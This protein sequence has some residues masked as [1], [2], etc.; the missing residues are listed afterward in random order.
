MPPITI[1]IKPASGMCNM[2]C[3]YCFY[4][5]VA[6]NRELPNYGIMSLSTLE[7]LMKKVFSY[8]EGSASFIFQGGEPTLAGL[9]FFGAVLAYQKEYNV[10]GVKV[11]NAIQTNGYAVTEEWA[12]FF[13]ENNFLVGL[14]LDGFKE[15]HDA[16][17]VD[18]GGRG[19]YARV[20]KT[21]AL[22]DAC[23]VE[24]NILCVVDKM[25]ARHPVK[26]YRALKK[27]RYLQF[28]PCMDDFD[29]KKQAH[30]LTAEAYGNFLK[31]TFDLYYADFIAGT[32]VSVRT[33]DNYI[34]ML[35]GRR[36]ESCAMNGVCGQYFLAEADGGIYPCDFY[37]L[38]DWCLGNVNT[39]TFEQMAES[40]RA[41]R[42]L[43]S[44][45][46]V[47]KKCRNCHWFRL[48][49]GGCRRDREPF[50]NGRPGLNR[51]CES[52]QMFFEYALP[53]MRKMALTL[54]EGR[55]N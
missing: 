2:R 28:I 14:S 54:A 29:G 34:G 16:V 38:D 17:R 8:A 19:T 9:D 7:K 24:Y 15:A 40:E 23:G 18:S 1:M 51:Y 46:Y 4:A 50:E 42:F 22:F 45:E 47:D 52:Y 11:W 26:T 13:A 33:F 5:D 53:S 20:V 55:Y 39:D 37:V 48:C 49:R 31:Q 30:S 36:P 21:A 41:V 44:S 43:K 6:A 32:P 27:Y 25:V 35:M 12:K 10:N 3:K